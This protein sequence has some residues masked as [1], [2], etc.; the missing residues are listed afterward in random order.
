MD[1]LT[2]I[3]RKQLMKRPSQFIF[4][5]LL[6]T[7]IF[8]I[9]ATK[10]QTAAKAA[11]PNKPITLM[12]PY[13][14][15]GVSDVI[16]RKVV[17]PLSKA[18]GVP[19]IV[20]NLGGAG[21]SIA[22]QKVLSAPSDG[23]TIFQGSPNELILA[24][25]AVSAV[26]YKP[27]DFRLVH[28]IATSPMAIAARK[29]LPANTPDELAAY[30]T[31][32]AA[33]GKPMTYASVGYGSFYH[34]LGEKMSQQLKAPML[35]VP[36]KGGGPIVNDLLGEQIDI[37]ISPYGA[38]QIDLAKSGKI[39]FIGA[40]SEQ[41]QRSISTVASTGESKALKGFYY[42]IGT[43]YYV[44]KGTPEPVAKA[45]HAAIT[46]VLQSH[47]IRSFLIAQSAEMAP[48]RDLKDS[49]AEYNKE[50]AE[51]AAIAK[52]VKLVPQ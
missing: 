46:S 34:L 16:A 33:E 14:P 15:G 4:Y 22:A 23:Y 26:K 42:R 40:V 36:Y 5:A 9:A 35:H 25:L 11:Y 20:E 37:F 52:S 27:S 7:L 24:P 18:L 21:G 19:V 8:S 41:R 12:V 39:K 49:T 51:F 32:M 48:Y 45:L 31:K 47:D 2:L 6:T 38:A 17:E 10:A 30:A 50:I 29:G 28:N 43:G 1:L 13:P 3:F 44:K